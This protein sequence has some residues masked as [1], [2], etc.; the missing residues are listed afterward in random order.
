MIG[1]VDDTLRC[2]LAEELKKISGCP[3]QSPEQIVFDAPGEPKKGKALV[4]LFLHNVCEN[5]S[6]REEP[7]RFSRKPDAFTGERRRPPVRMNLS[8]LVTTQGADSGE[9][10]RLLI[11]TLGVLLRNPTIPEEYRQGVLQKE[12]A[13]GMFLSVAQ[14]ENAVHSEAAQLWQAIGGPLRPALGL[15]VTAPFDP[16]RPSEIP[17]VLEVTTG[18]G[19]GVPPDGPQRPLDIARTRV[20]VAGVAWDTKRNVPL[21]NV[22]VQIKGHDK[23]ARTDDE[24]FFHF[25]NLTEGPQILVAERRGYQPLEIEVEVPPPGRSDLLKQTDV[26]MEPLE[27]ADRARA[28]ALLADAVRNAPGLLE[29]ERKIHVSLTGRLRLANGKPA[30][31][32]PVRV[33]RQR[34]QTDSE[35]VYH[36][37]DLPVG[38]HRVIA[39]LPGHGE[40]AVPRAGREEPDT[41]TLLLPAVEAGGA[42]LEVAGESANEKHSAAETL[43]K[44]KRG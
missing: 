2:L 16:F 42:G 4:N 23:Q 29:S 22:L 15:V 34:T 18:T 10:H 11:D 9:E 19:Q 13:N 7:F 1:D 40:V 25:L 17:V 37:F 36:F 33:G 21:N 35:G 31:Y 30:A 38:D 32:V 6:L 28:E 8:Y 20:G 27:E 12:D 44:G 39:D 3:V 43:R 5:T 26:K 14:P 41:T 24:G